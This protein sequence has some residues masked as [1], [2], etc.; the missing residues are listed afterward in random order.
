[1]KR[2][3]FILILTAVSSCFAAGSSYTF[4]KLPVPQI[5]YLKAPYVQIRDVNEFAH[6]DGSTSYDPKGRQIIEWKWDL[7][8]FNNKDWDF[9]FSLRGPDKAIINCKI[10]NIGCYRARLW[11]RTSDGRWNQDSDVKECIVYIIFRKIYADQYIAVGSGMTF[12]Y[13]IKLP[14]DIQVKEAC[15]NIVDE[16]KLPLA[17]LWIIDPVIGKEGKIEWDGRANTG[18]YAGEFI[19]AGQFSINFRVVPF[20][21]LNNKKDDTPEQQDQ[22]NNLEEIQ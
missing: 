21:S 12:K 20:L 6:F 16:Y 4:N 22:L 14:K 8:K 3:I 17:E 9:I 11:V 2:Y 7:Y 15:I 19:P 18:F 10:G 1:M 13:L 5:N